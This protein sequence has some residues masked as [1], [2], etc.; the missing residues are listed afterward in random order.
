M[1]GQTTLGIE[2]PA[3]LQNQEHTMVRIDKLGRAHIEGVGYVGDACSIL[4]DRLRNA[5]GGGGTK[6]DKPEAFAT[7]AVEQEQR[8]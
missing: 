8:W 4:G 3:H 6:E 2:T 5:L 7:G 1:T